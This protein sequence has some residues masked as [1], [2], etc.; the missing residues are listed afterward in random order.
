[1]M[2]AESISRV[3]FGKSLLKEFQKIPVPLYLKK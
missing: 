3:A 2:M 1:M